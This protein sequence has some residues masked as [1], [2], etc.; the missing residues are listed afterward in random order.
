M[1]IGDLDP[2]NEQLIQ[3]AAALLVE[4]FRQHWPDAWPDQE[5]AI[6]EVHEALAPERICRVA[7]DDQ[8]MPLG[9]VGANAQYSGKVWELHPL[10]VRP[11]AQ[12]QGVGRALMADLEA[13]VRERGGLTILLGT[14]DEDDMTS[15]SGVDLYPDVWSHIAY[16]GGVRKL[17]RRPCAAA[18]T[19][20]VLPWYG[21]GGM[22]GIR[23]DA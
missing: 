21:H 1:Q 23:P 17:A 18:P 9:W 12:G 13:R 3:Q 11:N 7:L 4:G 8:G 16:G 15:L 5:S 2:N 19:C 6:A 14:D 10:V 20:L 22:I